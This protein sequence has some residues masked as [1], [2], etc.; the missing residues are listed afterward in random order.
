MLNAVLAI[1]D[2]RN[3]AGSEYVQTV[4]DGPLE[5]L[6]TIGKGDMP[7]INLFFGTEKVTPANEFVDFCDTRAF[8]CTSPDTSC[9][10]L[11][12]S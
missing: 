3:L 4:D 1:S 8:R 12:S 6:A 2:A 10:G 11:G 9:P 5:M 7:N